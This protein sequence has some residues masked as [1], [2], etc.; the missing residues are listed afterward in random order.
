MK[1]IIK[2]FK[3]SWSNTHF[4]FKVCLKS[5][6]HCSH[7]PLV[8]SLNVKKRKKKKIIVSKRPIANF[9]LLVT[10]AK[11]RAVTVWLFPVRSGEGCLGCVF[12]QPSCLW[13][14]ITRH[15]L[16]GGTAA[17]GSSLSGGSCNHFQDN[18]LKAASLFSYRCL[19]L[20]SCWIPQA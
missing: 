3:T 1:Y 16:P 7:F 10:E 15:G 19:H 8:M 2:K 12:L 6:Y 4:W 11:G 5:F 17:S 14:L 9:P 18:L 13:H 20:T